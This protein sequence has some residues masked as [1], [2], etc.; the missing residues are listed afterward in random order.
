M[1]GGGNYVFLTLL[2]RKRVEAECPFIA[3]FGREKK[4]LYYMTDRSREN[5]KM[6]ETARRKKDRLYIS[7]KGRSLAHP[8]EP[9]SIRSHNRQNPPRRRRERK[10][11]GR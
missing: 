5:H 1:G 8:E 9:A 11:R 4:R 10:K 2:L 3:P 6:K 7:Q